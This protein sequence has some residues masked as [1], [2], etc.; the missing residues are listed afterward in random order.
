[1]QCLH[2]LSDIA[3]QCALLFR[4]KWRTKRAI[5]HPDG[6]VAWMDETANKSQQSRLACAIGAQNG[7]AFALDSRHLLQFNDCF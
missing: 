2:D 7:D 4:T 3:P 1:M 5:E 6:A